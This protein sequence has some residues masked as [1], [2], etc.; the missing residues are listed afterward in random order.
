[1]QYKIK[2]VGNVGTVITSPFL[3]SYLISQYNENLYNFLKSSE[4]ILRT[5]FVTLS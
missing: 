4:N 3:G 1:M 5:S 2:F